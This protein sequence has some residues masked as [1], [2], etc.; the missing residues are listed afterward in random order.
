MKKGDEQNKK[1]WAM[2]A[3][4]STSDYCFPNRIEDVKVLQAAM[5]TNPADAK[6]SYYLGNF[7]YANRQY[8][9]AI[10]SWEDAAKKDPSFPTVHRNLAL[11]YYNKQSQPWKALASLEKAFELDATDARVLMELDQLYKQINKPHQQRLELLEKHIALTEDRDDLYLE[12]IALYN[13][14][15]QF[16]KAKELLASR[17]FHPW[18]GGEGKVVGQYLLCHIELAKKAIAEGKFHDALHLLEQAEIYPHNLG[19]GKLYGVQENDIFYLKGCAYEGLKHSEKATE[20]FNKATIGLAEP[21]QAI[22]YNDQQPDKI[23]YQGLAW[24]KLGQSAKA[25]KIFHRLIDF[26]KEHLNDTVKIDYFAVSLPDLL[27]FDQDLNLR[28]KIHCHYLIGLGMLGLGNGHSEEA[29]K[30]FN[31]VLDKNISHSGAAV[32]KNMIE[33][34][35]S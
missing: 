35:V 6:A 26:G 15:G 33:A 16:E 28:N 30:H 8:T 27:V 13:H 24:R 9:E 10:S 34:A 12:R 4:V 29:E 3:A 1:S 23:F 31:F 5:E 22:Y 18:E 21:V 25:E 7:W 2:K 32:H 19:E 11:A 20:Y 14:L 17:K